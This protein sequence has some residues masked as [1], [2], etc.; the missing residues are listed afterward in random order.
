MQQKIYAFFFFLSLFSLTRTICHQNAEST[1]SCIWHRILGFHPPLNHHKNGNLQQP[2]T[3]FNLIVWSYQLSFTFTLFFSCLFCK[4]HSCMAAQLHRQS[5]RSI[6]SYICIRFW[7][8]CFVGMWLSWFL[9]RFLFRTDQVWN[10]WKYHKFGNIKTL[11]NFC[12]IIWSCLGV[13]DACCMVMVA[14]HS[15]S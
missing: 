13:E 4:V 7:D 12:I 2:C 6:R 11:L 14:L 15:L 9:I 8:F 10:I 1:F 5:L 3:Y